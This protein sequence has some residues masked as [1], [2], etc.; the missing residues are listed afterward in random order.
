M[1]SSTNNNNNN[2]NPIDSSS[3]IA[4]AGIISIA[5]FILIENRS[6][7]P[8]IDFGLMLNKR[9]LLANIIIMIVGFP[10]KI[11]NLLDLEGIP[12]VL[13][14]ALMIL[15]FGSA[16]GTKLGPMKTIIMGTVVVSIVLGTP[17]LVQ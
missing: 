7:A 13:P 9:I 3:K 8:L 16:S 15:I 2:N 11:P 6:A 14:F 10:F 5:L 4:I 1:G 12:L 17:L